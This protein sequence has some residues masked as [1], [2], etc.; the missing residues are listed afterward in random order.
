MGYKSIALH[1]ISWLGTFR[2]VTRIVSFARVV[3]LA[4]ILLPMQFGAYGIAH[5]VLTCVEILTE[6]GVN[7]VLIQQKEKI[8]RFIDSAWVVSIIRGFLIGG[9]LYFLSPFISAFFNSPESLPLIRLMSVVPLIKGFINPAIV[10][11]QKELQFQ[12][13]FWLRTAIF[14]VDSF[15]A[16]SVSFIT[17]DPSGIVFG[18][19]AGGITEVFLSFLFIR[20]LPKI[21]LDYGYI[22]KILHRGKWV[23]ASGIFT[24]VFQNG[25]NIAVGKLLGTSSLGLYQMAYSLSILPVSEITDVFSKV[26]FPIYSKI[27]DDKKRLQQAFYKIFLLTM[28]IA[29]PI[30]MLLFFFPER[31]I[32]FFLGEK[33][34]G[35]AGALRLLSV[36]GLIR[37][38]SISVFPL[39]LSLGKQEYITVITLVSIIGLGIAIIPF[40][41]QFGLVGAA[42]AVLL[43]SLL[44]LPFTLYYTRNIFKLSR[45]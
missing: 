31:I 21:R 9:T 39:F 19:I 35:A 24:Y 13:E 33:W 41:S 2:I 18:L 34:L 7:V 37:S 16:I 11:F 44:S 26:V 32:L 12:K 25:D 22:Q 43:G 45:A 23:T 30:S 28:A 15:T 36:F 40:I 38:V 42:Y 1:S 10:G 6:T 5:L 14:V 3:V 17:K 27:S 29:I 8:D 20:P 4:R